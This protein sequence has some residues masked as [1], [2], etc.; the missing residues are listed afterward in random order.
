[1]T[2]VPEVP[3]SWM[4]TPLPPLLEMTFLAAAI[5]PPTVFPVAIP[6]SPSV[7]WTPDNPFGTG[8]LP[9]ASS[10]MMLPSMVWLEVPYTHTP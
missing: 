10:P 1:M 6:E 2:T 9:V 3:E 5:G 7:T 8:V 4:W